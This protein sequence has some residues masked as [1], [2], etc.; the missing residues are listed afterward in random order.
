MATGN[1][2]NYQG[3]LGAA[4]IIDSGFD[5]YI[6][7]YNDTGA[8]ITNGAL[9]H[10]SYEKD[11]DSLDPSARP[12]LTACA[13]SSVYQHIVVVNNLPLGLGTI[14][15]QAYGYVQVRGY[16]PKVNCTTASQAIDRYLQGTN[17]TQAATDD[18]TSRT[19]D[20]FAIST[21]TASSSVGTCFMFGDRCIIG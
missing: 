1:V 12:T 8:A 14:A 20:S 11:A 4:D 10:L 15:D 19:T 18:G 13:T 17:G 5:R 3:A 16:C 7:V 6:K 21:S 9:Y 2:P